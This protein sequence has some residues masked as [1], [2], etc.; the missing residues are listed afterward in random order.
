LIEKFWLPGGW[1]F[2]A[3]FGRIPEMAN[4]PVESASA[5]TDGHSEIPLGGAAFFVPKLAVLMNCP[6]FLEKLDLLKSPYRVVSA[7][8]EEALRMFLATLEGTKPDLTTGNMNELFF[9]LQGVR[10][11]GAFVTGFGFPVAARSYRRRS[12][13][14]RLPR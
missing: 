1:S 6:K 5:I 14:S 3:A 7:V 4:L 12:P 11:C 13:Q 2:F 9:A 10:V 8:G